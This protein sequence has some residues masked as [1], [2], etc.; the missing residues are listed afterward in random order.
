[1]KHWQQISISS[2][3]SIILNN[4][5]DWLEQLAELGSWFRIPLINFLLQLKP[6]E[7]SMEPLEPPL[8]PPL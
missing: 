5:S 7:G 1:M 2:Y 8:D 6:K 4:Y 3:V